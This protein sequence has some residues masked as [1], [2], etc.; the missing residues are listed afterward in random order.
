MTP[1][2][3]AA[4]WRRPA[5]A[6]TAVAAARAEHVAG[7]AFAVDADEHVFL[8]G[9]LAADQGEVMA[10]RSWIDTDRDRSRRIGRQLHHLDALDQ[11]SRVRR[12]WMRSGD[13]ADFEPMLPGEPD[14]LGQA[15]HGAVVAHDFADDAHRP[16]TGQMDQ[17]DGRL[18]VA[19]ALRDPPGPGAKRE[20]VARLDEVLRDSPRIGQDAERLGAVAGADARRDASRGIHTHLEVGLE[21]LAVVVGHPLDAKLAEPVGCCGG[22]DQA[23]SELDHEIDR[24]RGDELGGHD[25][26]ALVLTT[27]VVHDN[28]HLALLQAGDDRL[29]SESNCWAINIKSGQYRSVPAPGWRYICPGRVSVGGISAR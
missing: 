24:L 11:L 23:A 6:G 16:A 28:H 27:G 10:R 14:Q 15:G 4:T 18:R 8:P 7:E 22:A 26:V 17:V 12:K 25:E 29:G 13:G 1:Q 3:A 20:H 9:D 21:G 2:P 5:G 19:S